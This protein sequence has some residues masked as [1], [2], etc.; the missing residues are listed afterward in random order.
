MTPDPKR[1]KETAKQGE[2]RESNALLG[3]SPERKKCDSF[4]ILEMASPQLSRWKNWLKTSSQTSMARDRCSRDSIAR[5]NQ[6]WILSTL[7]LHWIVCWKIELC[8]TF[9]EL[10]VLA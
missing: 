7:K 10:K 4:R 6:T 5:W 8:A 3:E 9:Q 1:S 2:T